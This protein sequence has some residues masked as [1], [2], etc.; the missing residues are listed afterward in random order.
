[1][2]REKV[3]EGLLFFN[4][5]IF[6]LYG[7]EFHRTLPFVPGERSG[8]RRRVFILTPFFPLFSPCS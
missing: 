4:V 6:S 8:L 1:M 3:R 7:W 5:L 2:K